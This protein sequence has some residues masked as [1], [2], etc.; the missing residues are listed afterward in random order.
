GHADVVKILLKVPGADPNVVPMG[1][2]AHPLIEASAVGAEAVAEALLED[3]RIDAT[4]GKVGTRALRVSPHTDINWVH[5]GAPGRGRFPSI[6]QD[7]TVLTLAVQDGEDRHVAKL[8]EHPGIDVNAQA[9]NGFTALLH[10]CQRGYHIK[11]QLLLGHPETDVNSHGGGGA[12]PLMFAAKSAGAEGTYSHLA[13][14]E[15]LLQNPSTDLDAIDSSGKTAYVMA[16]DRALDALPFK[17]LQRFLE[18]PRGNT[19]PSRAFLAVLDNACREE[20][21]STVRLLLKKG[22]PLDAFSNR[23]DTALMIAMSWAYE[24]A[25]QLILQCPGLDVTVRNSQFG[26][27]AREAL[28]QFRSVAFTVKRIRILKMI[29]DYEQKENNGL[30]TSGGVGGG[31]GGGGD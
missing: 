8:L 17:I 12:T 14:V 9:G 18:C 24:E 2:G 31:G 26:Y 5:P 11:A 3:P 20:D 15:S 22:M 7:Q 21:I 1:P 23:G 28:G 10:A 13:I 30:M 16:C 25:I 19:P 4:T 6:W 27:D 29:D